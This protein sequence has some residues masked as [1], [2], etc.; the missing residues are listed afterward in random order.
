MKVC[1]IH[2]P[3]PELLDDRL[4]PPVGLLY[5][6]TVL[7]Q[8]GVQASIVDLCGMAE[9]DWEG[10]IP[11][12]DFYGFS[13]YTANYHRTLGILD[14][15]KKIKPDVITI[16]GGPH[17]TACS[18]E[19]IKSFDYVVKGE[20]ER[21]IMDIVSKATP[22]GIV[23]GEPVLDLSDLPYPD[24]DLVDLGSYTRDFEGKFALPIFSSRS[25]PFRC[26][27]C[28]ASVMPGG[29]LVRRRS[30][31]DFVGEI[32]SE[33][34]RYGDIAFRMK[35]DLFGSNLPWLRRFANAAPKIEYSCNVRGDC[36]PEILDILAATGCK[37]A[38]IGVESGDD[39]ILR[40]MD[41]RLTV[42]QSERTVRYAKA[43][44]IKVLGWFVVG[45]P[46][47]TWDT[48]KRTVDFIQRLEFDKVIIY[49]LIPYPGTPIGDNPEKYGIR[50]TDWDYSHYFYRSGN[51]EAGFVYETDDLSPSLIKEMREYVIGRVQR[52]HARSS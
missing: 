44:G 15:V 12:A 17:A 35:D 27:F 3:V 8:S 1:F 2:T 37:W 19:V 49:P 52:T 43:R 30:V 36:K 33:L 11:E 9:S 22:K 20:G 34:D 45:F 4:D 24:Y 32:E 5:M 16:A 41:K 42:A 23:Q 31:E 18:E 46:G 28:S 26:A 47:E 7:N 50:I 29:S 25:C 13:T 51:Y 14:L 40:M 10:S 21:A 39:S 48:V 38:C 6:A